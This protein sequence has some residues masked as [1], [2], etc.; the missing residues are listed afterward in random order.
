MVPPTTFTEVT[1]TPCPEEDA[2]PGETATPPAP[3][4]MPTT[5]PAYPQP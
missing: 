3:L 1:M 4:E 2:Y 5:P